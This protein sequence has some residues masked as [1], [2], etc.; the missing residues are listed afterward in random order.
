MTEPPKISASA[1]IVLDTVSGRILYEKNAHSRRAMASTTKIM[2]AI[3]AIENGNLDDKVKVSKRAASIG[4]SV[5]NLQAGEE[6]SLKELLYGMLIKSGNDA[7]IAVAEHIGGSVE[8]FVKMMNKK[9]K[10]LG[11]KDTAFKNPM[12]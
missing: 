12:D 6:L 5:I 11:L 9:A 2:T 10:D 8:D 3:V 7:A 4:G 1:A